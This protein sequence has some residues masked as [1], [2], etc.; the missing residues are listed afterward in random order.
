M[1]KLL[2]IIII[3]VS[4]ISVNAQTYVQN[5]QKV[6]ATDTVTREIQLKDA[7]TSQSGFLLKTG[8]I[9]VTV[10]IDPDNT[11]TLAF[12]VAPTGLTFP[13]RSTSQ[14]F[15][16]SDGKFV[17]TLYVPT[18]TANR[19]S[20]WSLYYKASASGNAFTIIF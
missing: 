5:M 10:V 20:A 6:T 15:V 3:F 11:G 16:A 17:T 1:K 13:I 8:I 4:Y 19:N 9:E 18:S 2:L 14:G 12:M 7:Y